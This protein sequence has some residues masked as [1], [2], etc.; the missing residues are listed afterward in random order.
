MTI[1][2]PGIPIDPL[3]QRYQ[4]SEKGKQLQ[5]ADTE[6]HINTLVRAHRLQTW[7][8]SGYNII[9]GQRNLAV[10]QLVPQD[11]YGVFQNKLSGFYEKFRIKPT[12]N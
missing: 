6:K 7:G 3:N 9:N 11:N 2:S 8:T 10:Q 4:N 5:Q 12:N 1:H